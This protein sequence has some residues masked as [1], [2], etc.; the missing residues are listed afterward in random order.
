MNI[1]MFSHGNPYINGGLSPVVTRHVDYANSLKGKVFLIYFDPHEGQLDQIRTLNGFTA[2]NS[3]AKL[4]VMYPIC[5]LITFYRLQRN[6]S[7][8][9]IYSQDAFITGFLGV[10]CKLMFGAKLIV[11]S[12]ASFLDNIDWI[13]EK[14]IQ[15]RMFNWISKINF[16]YADGI[17]SVSSEEMS[18]IKQFA[19]KS[20]KLLVQ[21]TPLT[22]PDN[23]S[24][25]SFAEYGLFRNDRIIISVGRLTPQK[26]H[27][28]LV[29][30]VANIAPETFDKLVIVGNGPEQY[31][32]MLKDRAKE[33]GLGNKF[34]L[35]P[36]LEHA[37]LCSLYKMSS[38]YIHT[39]LYEGVCKTILEAAAFS[40]PTIVFEISGLHQSIK[41]DITGVII[42]QGR[43][44]LFS[45]ALSELLLNARMRLD[46]GA[47][48][49][50]FVRSE[51]SYDSM[52]SRITNFWREVCAE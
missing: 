21:N 48:A 23:I 33:L 9:L 49:A 2:V 7:F 38:V 5:V 50:K 39:A 41:K 10:L 3:G 27:S 14:P 45:E 12:H 46:M 40:L 28:S 32:K 24:S 37:E 44:D 13:Q 42:P 31:I 29:S 51:H 47:A 34:V 19:Q 20:T 36:S 15:N 6:E 52:I 18:K 43:E 22:L 8:D 25:N 35:I 11:G 1:C 17:K 16:R 26:N 30:I 4:K